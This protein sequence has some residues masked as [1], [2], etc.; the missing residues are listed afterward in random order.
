MRRSYIL[1]AR[2]RT[3]K[4][5]KITALSVTLQLWPILPAFF[6]GLQQFTIPLLLSSPSI[7]TEP[8]KDF[9]ADLPFQKPTGKPLLCRFL[10]GGGCNHTWPLYPSWGPNA[11]Q[12]ISL[13]SSNYLNDLH[14]HFGSLTKVTC[15]HP[16]HQS[17]CSK[18]WGL[19]GVICLEK[20]PGMTE[21]WEL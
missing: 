21:E 16:A 19:S 17:Q 8:A 10:T 2:K 5:L 1:I 11:R 18:L 20:T 4:V 13:L 14:S 12:W 9:Q 3:R 6:W 7:H 15:A